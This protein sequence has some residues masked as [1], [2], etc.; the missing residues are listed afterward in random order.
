M[1][2]HSK[3]DITDAKSKK[4]QSQ[5]QIVVTFW[6]LSSIL[7]SEIIPS[8]DPL[9]CLFLPIIQK[10]SLCPSPWLAQKLLKRRG[11]YLI[12]M[13]MLYCVSH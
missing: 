4:N 8:N 7:L 3:I 9:C 10:L 11:L 5:K 12:H 13:C 6:L 1:A 2:A